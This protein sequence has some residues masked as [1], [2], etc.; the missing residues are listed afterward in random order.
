MPHQFPKL[1]SLIQSL[2]RVSRVSQ[3]HIRKPAQSR[4]QLLAEIARIEE[5]EDRCLLTPLAPLN[6]AATGVSASAITVSWSS[7]PDPQVTGYNVYEK[8]WIPGTH[9]GKGSPGPGQ[10]V[11]NLVG[12]NLHAT[13]DT[14]AGLAG[15]STHDYVVTALSASGASVYSADAAAQTWFAP[16]FANGS[17][18]FL[19][20][21]GALWSGP[22]SAQAGLSTQISLLINGN[23]L[24]YSVVSG[25]STVSINSKTGVVTYTPK[26]GEVG[27]VNV[28]FQAANSLGSVTQTIQFNV[29]APDARPGTPILK[30][31]AS[32]STYN[33]SG[34]PVSAGV[35]AS[36][37]VTPL[38]GSVTVTY[39]GGKGGLPTN[40][41]SYSI[42]VTFTS[43]DPNYHSATW[44]TNYTIT[45]A[46]PVFTSLT[47][48]TIAI[49]TT[50]ATFT[51]TISSGGTIP[52]GEGVLVTVNGVSQAAVINSAGGFSVSFA[53]AAL[54]LGSYTVT[55]QFPG[56]ANYN[57][58]LTGKSTLAVIPTAP[59]SITT[60]PPANAT[61]TAGDFVT[62][63]ASAT[64]SPIPTVQWQYSID[65]GQTWLN[66]V[67]NTSATT[68]TLTFISSTG[69]NGKLF[70]AVFTNR[71]GTA[72]S[73][74]TL[75]T[76]ETDTS[77]GGGTDN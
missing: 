3:S 23:P 68:T 5:F 8:I 1:M 43:S 4:R 37:G 16:S 26:A 51:G 53:T 40:V 20:S 69:D 57:A 70:R 61:T 52:K 73:S 76:V 27:T 71:V 39:N 19:L 21:S 17:N 2:R 29:T 28:T 63:S 14:I 66:I 45:R 30:L 50:T 59:P 58:A 18:I 32:S 46:T 62:L 12:S 54:P 60:N 75:L 65:G 25:P 22:V 56:D 42:L 7:F 6:V 74:S 9:G 38:T 15:G 47:S 64:G 44:L 36:D 34:Q 11:Y 31:A 13:A 72:I 67:G 41:G 35:V 48:Q 10:Y 33:G 49:G 77:G 24:N 55:Y